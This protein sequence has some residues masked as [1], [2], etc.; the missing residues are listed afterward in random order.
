MV[1][2]ASN[3]IYANIKPDER[4]SYKYNFDFVDLLNEQLLKGGVCLAN[5]LNDIYK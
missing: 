5:I 1:L 2:Q 4:L 3:R